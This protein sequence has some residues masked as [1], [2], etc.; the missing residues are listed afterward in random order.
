MGRKL[1]GFGGYEQFTAKK[2]TRY[3]NSPS[4]G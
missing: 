2:V 1:F 4:P 3:E